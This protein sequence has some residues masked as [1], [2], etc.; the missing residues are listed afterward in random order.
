MENKIKCFIVEKDP[1]L[2]FQIKKILIGFED[3][4]I[5]GFATSKNSAIDN[6]LKQ[7]PT[8]VIAGIE[9]D[10]CTFFEIL[11]STQSQVNFKIIFLASDETHALDAVRVN[12]DDYIMKPLDADYFSRTFKTSLDIVKNDLNRAKKNNLIQQSETKKRIAIPMKEYTEFINVE[13][14]IYF[15]ADINYC[16]IYLK[17]KKPIL[18]SKTLKNFDVNLVDNNEFIRIHQSYLININHIKRIIKTRLPQVAMSNGA[19]LSVSRGR[20]SEFVKHVLV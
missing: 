19:I 5:C 4:E 3:I 10:D 9:L 2:L 13:D 16:Y 15:Q 20:K 14:I 1:V 11:D 18:V 7:K 17:D 12:A 6:I 8:I